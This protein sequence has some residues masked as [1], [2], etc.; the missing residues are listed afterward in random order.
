MSTPEQHAE[1]RRLYF[2]EHWKVGTIAAALDVHH[3]TVRAA[4]AH[5]TRALPRG[6]CRPTQLDRAAGHQVLL[7][8]IDLADLYCSLIPSFS[9]DCAAEQAAFTEALRR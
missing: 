1:I 6:R 3:D 9:D 2:G 8:K 5:D 4:I 7:L